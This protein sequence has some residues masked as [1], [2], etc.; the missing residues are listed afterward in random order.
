MGRESRPAVDVAAS[1][2]S[3]VTGGVQSSFTFT[4]IGTIRPVTGR[5]LDA[6]TFG[7]RA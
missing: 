1:A 2:G 6:K 3:P 4:S 5:S 7:C